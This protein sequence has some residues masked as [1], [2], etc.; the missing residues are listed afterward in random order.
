[1]SSIASVTHNSMEDDRTVA[2]SQL[3]RKALFLIDQSALTKA[4]SERSYDL[5]KAYNRINALTCCKSAEH[6]WLGA[7]YSCME[8][9]T[10]FS[11]ILQIP[12]I[13]LAKGHAAAGQYAVL[14]AAGQLKA[15]D[16]KNYK[17][18]LCGLEAHADLVMDTGSLGQCLSSV[19]GMATVN[20]AERYAVILGDGE[21]QEG[22]I[23]ESLMTI[24]KYNLTNI[25][26]VVDQNG[27]QSDN[28]VD[29]IMPINNLE[30]ILKGFGFEVINVNGH[31]EEQLLDAYS[32]IVQSKILTVILATTVK[33]GGSKYL[34]PSTHP[35]TGMEYHVS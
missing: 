9:L 34:S 12:N 32:Q 6:G 27:F 1:M 15:E 5:L 25:I 19:A 33:A 30:A 21:M 3:H 28:V 17:N 11:L 26:P 2:T 14:Y 7:S 22:Q 4:I 13:I 24:K 29:E 35:I 20:K 8:I 16:L 18:G 10:V 23:Y 31:N